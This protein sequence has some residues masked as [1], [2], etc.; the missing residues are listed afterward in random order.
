MGAAAPDAGD[1]GGGGGAGGAGRAR[2]GAGGPARANRTLRPKNDEL[3]RANANLREAVGQK[4]AANAALA[5]A[6]GRVQAR[7]ELAREAIRSFKAG[8]RGGRSAEGGPAA[9]A[10]EQAAGLGPAVL[11][12]AGRPARGPVRRRL[13]GGAGRVVHGAGRAD[14]QDRP[15]TGGAGGLQEGGGD[16]PRAGGA[17][18][19]GALGAG[20]AGPRAERPGWGAVELGDH[21]GALAVHEEARALAEPLAAGPGA[22]I[23]ARRALGSALEG[24]G[25]ALEATGKVVEALAAFRRARSVLEALA[26]DGAAVPDDRSNLAGHPQRSATCWSGPATWPG[27]WPSSGRARS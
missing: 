27:R 12:P 9:A 7:F 24:S 8:S 17:A 6:N 18:G 22:T 2:G 26:R 14:R 10:A 16:P 20:R 19:A 21:A 4:D 11:R 13:E 25:T 15:E 1:G 5:E 3:D 23:E